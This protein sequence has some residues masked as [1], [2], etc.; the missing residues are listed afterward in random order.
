MN[1]DGGF[2]K[3]WDHATLDPQNLIIEVG[4]TGKMDALQRAEMYELFNRFGIVIIQHA[5]VKSDD[6]AEELIDL[7]KMYGKPVAHERADA[8][9]VV[10]VAEVPG[11]GATIGPTLMHTAGTFTAW[12]N[13][14]KTVILQCVTQSPVGG[15]SMIASGALAYQYLREKEPE[16][17]RLLSDPRVFSLRRADPG[18]GQPAG[19][20]A[21]RKAVFNHDQLGDGRIWLSFRFDGEVSLD[22]FPDEAHEAYDKLFCFLNRSENQI[23]FKLQPNQVL[24]CD[25]TAVGH[26]RTAYQVGSGRKLNRLQLYAGVGDCVFGFPAPKALRKLQ[27]A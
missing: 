9:G 19:K 15:Q 17:L 14:P 20:G 1:A 4:H 3:L 5:P 8:R 24:I 16:A 12:A 11:K 13:V 21:V 18:E 2:T 26:A 10:V 27:A 22:L 25:N 6:P 23:D 7:G